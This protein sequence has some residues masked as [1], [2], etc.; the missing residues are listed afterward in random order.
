MSRTNI[1][2]K[3]LEKIKVAGHWQDGW[4]RDSHGNDFLATEFRLRGGRK[5]ALVV[6]RE[7]KIL[8]LLNPVTYARGE[9]IPP[10]ASN[11]DFDPSDIM[12]LCGQKVIRSR[13]FPWLKRHQDFHLVQLD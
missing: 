1:P 12:A 8:Y 10:G 2:E 7:G 4:Q 5:V 3:L 9:P 13:F 6:D 11:F